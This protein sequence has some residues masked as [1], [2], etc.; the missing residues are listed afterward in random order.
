MKMCG[1][2]IIV[3]LEHNGDPIIYPCAVCTLD[4]E[5]HMGS[6]MYSWKIKPVPQHGGVLN[7]GTECNLKIEWE[8]KQNAEKG[9]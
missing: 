3:G 2:A 6:H 1:A 9:N 5:P 4:G 8:W 7:E